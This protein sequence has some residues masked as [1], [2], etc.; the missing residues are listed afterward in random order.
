MENNRI[1]TFHGPKFIFFGRGAAGKIPQ[2]IAVVSPSVYKNFKALLVKIDSNP[3][4]FAR[5]GAL[6]E[7]GEG[8]VLTLAGILRKKIKTAPSLPVVAVGGGS[9][10]DAVKIA[11]R[12]ASSD[13]LTFEK[14]YN[15][16]IPRPPKNS[17]YLIAV[18]TTAG[19]GTGVTGVAVVTKKDNV[20]RGIASPYLIP[21]EAYYDPDFI[22]VLPNDIFASSAMDALTHAI[23][24]YVSRIENIPADTMAL[25]AA[26][27]IGNNIIAGYKGVLSAREL[28]HYGNMM[29][30]YAF[31]N[32]RLGLCHALAHLIGGR[33]GVSHGRINAILLP[34]VIEH[35]I[36]A[37]E[38]YDRIAFSLGISVG[39]L[40]KH[41]RCLNTELGI[42]N[43]LSF[44]GE[45][46]KSMINTI[47][48]EASVSSLMKVNPCRLAPAEIAEMLSRLYG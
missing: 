47:A 35:N 48:E 8:D 10:I 11:V 28:V 24:A 39:G 30:G 6:R 40:A 45:K 5:R 19:T 22:D 15:D 38:K 27:M 34:D 41:I 23:E 18:E 33:F 25:K 46:F 26:E 7:P 16:G 12:I 36:E 29:A 43:S 9:V 37:A 2:G 4:L 31:S 14:I 21:D 42:A 13:G 20:K 17:P 1:N 32:A 44:L 3:V